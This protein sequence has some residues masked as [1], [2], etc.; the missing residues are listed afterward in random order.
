MSRKVTI[1]QRPRPRV[2]QDQRMAHEGLDGDVPRS[3]LDCLNRES[4][5]RLDRLH[6]RQRPRWDWPNG[7]GLHAVAIDAAAHLDDVSS[8]I[9]AIAP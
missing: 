6:Q 8:A 5:V 7:K 3:V 1:N 2:R 9:P 4:L